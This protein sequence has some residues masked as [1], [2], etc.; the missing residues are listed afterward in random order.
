[1]HSTGWQEPLL[2]QVGRGRLLPSQ[3]SELQQDVSLGLCSC[4][5]PDMVINAAGPRLLVAHT[6]GEHI[7]FSSGL[8]LNTFSQRNWDVCQSSQGFCRQSTT[9]CPQAPQT[10]CMLSSPAR[11]RGKQWDQP[12]D[13]AGGDTD[14]IPPSH[15]RALK[16]A[17]PS[18]LRAASDVGSAQVREE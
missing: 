9:P 8:C 6:C 17:A 7:T 18:I 16:G 2:S 12:W 4:W 5:H 10:C 11:C 14:E 3:F 15:E 13:M 1:M